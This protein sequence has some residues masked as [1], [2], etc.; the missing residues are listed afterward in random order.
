MI[1][2][3]NSFGS[4]T[5]Y[6]QPNYVTGYLSSFSN[7]ESYQIIF[8]TSVLGALVF[9][10]LQSVVG[11][12]ELLELLNSYRLPI[13]NSDFQNFYI[14]LTKIEYLKFMILIVFFI[15]FSKKIYSNKVNNN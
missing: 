12:E 3:A 6:T 14:N 7:S 2:T 4:I 9:K 5:K 10:I 15:F 11:Y 13:T 1:E 8:L